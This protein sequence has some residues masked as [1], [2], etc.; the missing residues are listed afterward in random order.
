MGVLFC[1]ELFKRLDDYTFTLTPSHL[2]SASYLH[3]SLKKKKIKNKNKPCCHNWPARLELRWWAHLHLKWL[4]PYLVTKNN[5]THMSLKK[6]DTEFECENLKAFRNL[7]AESQLKGSNLDLWLLF[8]NCAMDLNGNEFA[9]HSG[10][11]CQLIV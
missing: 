3:L 10:G 2:T 9:V 5:Y 4:P 8:C 1:N 6:H 7:L 11:L